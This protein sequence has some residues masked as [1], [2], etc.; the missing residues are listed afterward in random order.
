MNPCIALN[1]CPLSGTLRCQQGHRWGGDVV[2]RHFGWWHLSWVGVLWWRAASWHIQ[3]ETSGA[4]SCSR[5]EVFWLTSRSR[6]WWMFFQTGFV[7]K[8]Q[9]LVLIHMCQLR[10]MYFSSKAD[11]KA[12]NQMH[13]FQRNYQ[14]N[15]HPGCVQWVTVFFYLLWNLKPKNNFIITLL[16]VVT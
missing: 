2:I 3:V 4:T 10:A 13:E 14:C 1:P 5:V 9:C 7:S 8:N 11:L 16:Y 15:L 12:R 6:F